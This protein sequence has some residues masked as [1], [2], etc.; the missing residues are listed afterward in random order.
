MKKRGFAGKRAEG[1]MEMSF[2]M[3]FTVILIVF[4]ILV[5]FMAIRYLLKL[6]TCNQIGGFVDEF[7]SKVTDIWNSQKEDYELKKTLPTAIEYVC[8]ANLEDNFKGDNNEILEELEFYQG[9]FDSNMFIY[10]KEKACDMPAQ[11][12]KHLDI[13]KITK[14]KNPYCIQVIR[15]KINIKIEKDFLDELVT[16]SCVIGNCTPII[17]ITNQTSH[18]EPEKTKPVENYS[19]NP[20][21]ETEKEKNT[22][23][24]PVGFCSSINDSEDARICTKAVE[25]QTKDSYTSTQNNR[26]NSIENPSAKN[27]CYWATRTQYENLNN[28][29]SQRDLSLCDE[30]TDPVMKDLCVRHINA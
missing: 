5:S 6:Q 26:C 25:E 16:I 7:Q 27:Q 15:G 12:I 3:I 19:V 14:T 28:R 29:G 20:I 17:L 13:E 10:P 23:F 22:S 24:N 8:F 9:G 18:K 2:S 1:S 21:T 4:F 30:F 11:K